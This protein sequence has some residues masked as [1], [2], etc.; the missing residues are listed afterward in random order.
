MTRE[1]IPLKPDLIYDVGMHHGEDTEFYLASG[2]R[3]LAI[4]ADPD[5]AKKASEHFR[6]AIESG[7]L[8]ILN[9]GLADQASVEKFWICESN[10]AWNSFDISIASR[11]GSP[12]H[13]ID[14]PTQRFDEILRQ[15]GIPIYVKIDI[16]GRDELCLNALQ[17]TPIPKFIS[18]EDGGPDPETRIPRVLAAMNSLGYRYFNLV[19]QR[20]FRPL[21]R[22]R[23]S[24]YKPSLIERTVNSAAYGR[25]RVPLLSKLAEP[26]TY[27]SALARRNG[28]REFRLGSSGP[29]GNCIPGGWVSF[30]EACRLH[31]HIRD[32]HFSDPEANTWSFWC[33]WH[34]TTETPSGV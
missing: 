30:D 8:T 19:S 12:H 15:F 4:D 16:E 21:F 24:R 14:V 20:D 2:F 5:L 22:R 18:A 34:A 10:S 25:L 17:H 31:S 28:G 33:D 26:L 6:D 11:D 13:S 1:N 3:V 27:R 29:W 9:V 32:E 7:R 23:G